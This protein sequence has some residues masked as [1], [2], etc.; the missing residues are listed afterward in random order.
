MNK[1]KKNKKKSRRKEE[2]E[3]RKNRRKKEM[4][5]GALSVPMT[6]LA[7]SGRYELINVEHKRHI[8]TVL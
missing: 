2:R 3:K 1:T 8:K 4:R 5:K 7:I 6:L